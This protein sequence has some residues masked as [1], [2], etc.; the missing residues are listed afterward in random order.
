M[1]LRNDKLRL[2]P[3]WI[4]PAAG[5][6]DRE[7]R[8]VIIVQRRRLLYPA[9]VQDY[10]DRVTA[11]DVAAG[12]TSGLEVG[13]TDAASSFL[14]DLVSISY[15]GISGGV[16]SQAASVIKASPI[17]AGARTLPGALVPVVGTAPTNVNNLFVPSDYNRKTGLKG[18]GTTKH[19]NSNRNNNADPQNSKHIAA[20][21]TATTGT[22]TTAVMG[23]NTVAS[24]GSWVSRN[25]DN[26]TSSQRANSV[27]SYSYANAFP[28]SSKLLGVSR[29]ASNSQSHIAA[30]G[31]QSST[32][33]SA[34][35]INENIL[36]FRA[37]GLFC[38][39][40]IAFYSIG[41]NLDLGLLDT[42]VASLISAY[43]AAIP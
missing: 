1:A 41:E 42:R 33:A 32:L 29:S 38:P 6:P 23:T 35:P 10:L 18:N 26:A 8:P 39:F 31:V 12:N 20:F 37:L 36:V 17:M 16:I 22:G 43:A 5:M 3:T 2:S 11:A 4:S 7:V 25:S 15:L 27:A 13:V 34:A 14:Q 28:I 19:L 21:I 9:Y 30:G 24:G 40:R